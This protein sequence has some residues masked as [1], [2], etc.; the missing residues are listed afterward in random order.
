MWLVSLIAWV[1]TLAR[2]W[3][4]VALRGEASTLDREIAHSTRE[5]E[6]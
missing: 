3:A 4:L 1:G 5:L 6:V 2:A